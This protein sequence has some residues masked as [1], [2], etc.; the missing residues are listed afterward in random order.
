MKLLSIIVPLYNSEKYL[1]KCL[2]SLVAQ[3]ISPNDYEIILVDDGSPD[4]SRLVAEEYASRHSNIIVLSQPN[5]GTSG[6]RN[7]GLRQ[8]AG[9]YV[10]F[11]DPDDYILENS[12]KEPLETME[13]ESLDVLRF[14]YTEVDEQY[15]P[16]SSVKNRIDMDYTPGIMN[17]G[18]FMATRL[19]V[20]CYVWSFIF[21]RALILENGLFFYEGYYVDDTPWLPRVLLKAQRVDS[22]P[23]KRHFYLIRK[24]SLVR[25]KSQASIDKQRFGLIS[26]VKELLTQRAGNS[27]QEADKWY[28]MT[29]SHCVVFL[30]SLISVYRF[31]QRQTVIA[32]LK[33]FKVFP[34]SLY[35][36][37]L[38]TR[39]KMML[40]NL[41]P[42][43]YCFVFRVKNSHGQ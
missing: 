42:S 8:A 12:L 38:P 41:S 3:D 27:D 32:Q 9:K 11:V 24:D 43:F 5:K 22:T 4:N 35:R 25:A 21:R 13:K 34:L 40:I 19:G 36:A 31:E 29:I 2:D 7:T 37:S 20:A 6:A 23:A 30:L 1:P 10:Y 39:L 28:R 15:R 33:S 17:G 18:R 16:T 14:A 26:V